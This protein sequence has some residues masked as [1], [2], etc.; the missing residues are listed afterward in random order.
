MVDGRGKIVM[1]GFVDL[2]THLWQSLIRGCVT[3]RELNGWLGGCVLPL[4]GTPVSGADAYA[5]AHLSTL[6]AISTGV[7]TVTDW[8]HPFNADFARGNLKALVESRQR[9]VFAFMAGTDAWIARR[10]AG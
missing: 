4:Q 10:F 5:G 6:D 2:H 3:D 7:T 9:F 8:S 1:R